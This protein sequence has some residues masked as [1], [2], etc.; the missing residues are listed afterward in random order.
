M[1]ELENPGSGGVETSVQ[2]RPNGRSPVEEAPESC[3][4]QA[5]DAGDSLGS[6]AS[7]SETDAE[8]VES[9]AAGL[10]AVSYA[11]QS[12]P[13]ADPSDD[14][15]PVVITSTPGHVGAARDFFAAQKAAETNDQKRRAREKSR[16]Y[17]VMQYLRHPKTGEPMFAQELLD[18]GLVTLKDR[19]HRWCYIWHDSDQLV[20]V[21]EG[22][23]DMVCIGVKG[24]HVHMVLWTTED[25]PT[26]RTVSD[27]FSI[28]SARVKL[29]KEDTARTGGVQH[30]GRDAAEKAFFDFAEYL[31]HETR[32]ASGLPGVTQPER[33][34]LVDRD[35]P[36]HPGKYQYGR[37]RVV[38]DFDFS[39]ELDAH[40]A[41]RVS[42]AGG[43]EAKSLRAR[44]LKLRR[45]VGEGMSLEDARAADFDA[46]ADDLPRL[47]ELAREYDA[48]QGRERAA[49]LGNT[50]QKSLVVA[51]GRTRAGKDVLL[52]ELVNQLVWLVGLAGASWSVVKP[53]G[54]N[55]L[56][57]I[58]RAEIVHHEDARYELLPRYDEAL[59]YLDPN[60]AVE[61]GTRHKNT[62]APTP[63]AILM[64]SSETLL[65]LAYTLKRRADSEYLAE[66][67]SDHKTAP[68]LP[69]NVDE[70]LYRIGWAVEVTKPDHVDPDDFD[71]VRAEMLVA[72]SRVREGS[73]TRIE[74]VVNGNGDYIGKIRTGHRLDPVAVIKGCDAAARF[75][76]VSILAER[77]P[78]V[79]SAI[80]VEALTDL[81]EEQAGIES[82]AHA[83]RVAEEQAREIERLQRQLADIKRDEQRRKAEAQTREAAS[84]EA[85]RCTC[86]SRPY[87]LRDHDD[88]CPRLPADER[89]RRAKE[90]RVEA[91]NKLEKLRR[92]GLVLDV[93]NNQTPQPLAAVR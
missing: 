18:E 12:I 34:Y 27:A 1:P 5:L 41:G 19:L 2:K 23:L 68:K 67:A 33:Y 13:G 24:E 44:K 4:D 9:D 92:N 8:F 85:A 62:A 39:K 32:S 93:P 90:R 47:R 69:L 87:Y 46:Y 55:T 58:G 88:A 71:A 72:V 78:D 54:R 11:D 20:E 51:V 45:A 36:G 30:K 56:E 28:P 15:A 74:P 50:W 86:E 25:R 61:A 82:A 77:N 66:L 7:V 81:L 21:D 14:V 83:E 37:G 64:S 53:A 35:Q 60:D 3:S 91:A 76:A 65:S 43:G 38:A 52:T 70:F 73:D 29:P 26:L 89:E 59:R 79:T 48:I 49:E 63:R 57:G 22:T 16:V 80:P 84:V 6:P 10:V 17:S 31:T 75:L 42:A 40:M